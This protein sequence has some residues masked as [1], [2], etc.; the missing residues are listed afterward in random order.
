MHFHD[1]LAPQNVLGSFLTTC[2]EQSSTFQNESLVCAQ[3]GHT[4]IMRHISIYETS[5][6]HS[7]Y[8]VF[9]ILEFQTGK[10]MWASLRTLTKT[11]G[12]VAKNLMGR[13]LAQHE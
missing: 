1:L 4:N 7:L 5:Y 8:H 6:V 10:C 11:R 12:D 9:S 3:T 13:T 2:F